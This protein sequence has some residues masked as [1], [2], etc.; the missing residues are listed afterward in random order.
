[1]IFITMVIGHVSHIAYAKAGQPERM[2]ESIVEAGENIVESII[3]YS[4][5]VG[6][7]NI[8]D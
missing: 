8:Q 5:K 3:A 1:L 7:Q 2:S 4:N 6:Q